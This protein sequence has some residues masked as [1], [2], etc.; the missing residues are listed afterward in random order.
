MSLCRPPSSH[1]AIVTSGGCG[2][3]HHP[4]APLPGHEARKRHGGNGRGVNSIFTLHPWIRVL[5]SLRD[6][7]SAPHRQA[8][9]H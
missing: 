7:I 1:G 8:R 3:T 5:V 9:E 4:S 6:G 2:G